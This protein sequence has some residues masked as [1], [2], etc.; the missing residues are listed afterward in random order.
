MPATT[1][2]DLPVTGMTC[3]GC[4]R[5]I[6]TRL[7]KEEGVV[8]S[9]VS[10]PAGSVS[11]TYDSRRVGRD[12]IV[13][14]IRDIGFDVPEAAAG[15]SLAAATEASQRSHA[16]QQLR[17]VFVAA[18]LTIP[19][20]VLS[21]GRDFGIW[22]Q[23]AYAPWVN[24]LLFALATPVQFYCGWQF[25]VGTYRSIRRRLANMDMLVAMSTTTAYLYSAAV[26]VAL[27]FG[28]SILGHHVYFETSATIITLILLGRQIESRAQAR[29][30]SAIEKLLR[31]QPTTAR[32]RRNGNEVELETDQ[33]RRG[34]VVIVRPGERIPFDGNVLSGHS[35]VD[36]SM[37]TGE[38]LPVEKQP[39]MEV[40]G[41]TI[42]RQGLLTVEV[43]HVADESALAQI[44][45]Q[46]QRAQAT[47]APIQDLA[48]RISSLFV[49]VVIAVALL[50]LAVWW[51][52]LGQPLQGMLRMI[53]VL[54]ISCPCAMGL[55][56]PLA[57]TVGMG[58][59]G[60]NGILF[61][62]STALQ[63]L[64]DVTHV[65]LD[66]TGTITHGKLAVTDVVVA[67]DQSRETVLRLAAAAEQGSEHPVAAAIVAA[68]QQDRLQLPFP[69]EFAADPGQGV[70][71]VVDG[72]TIRVGRRGWIAGDQTTLP[73]HLEL[74]ATELA[75]QAKSIN[76]V[77]RG[78]RV[79]GL[80]AF[81]DTIKPSSPSA[82]AALRNAG[83][84]VSMITGDNRTTADAVAAK[85]GI[86]RVLAE[87]LPS[88]KFDR[89]DALKQS[90]EVVAMVG[91]GINDAPALAAAD[92]GVAIGTG[93]DVAIESAGV[94]L[95][96]GEL[97]L[98]SR[99]WRLSKATMRNIRQNLFWAFAYNVLLIPVAA[100]A[101]A[102]FSQLPLM[103]RELHP[104]MAALA[105]V[106][107]DL[108]IVAN[109][110][111]L[112]SIEIG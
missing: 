54:I 11:I 34:D 2:V 74:A 95:I 55:A 45:R 18:A 100:G 42:N 83:L 76:C 104:M 20:F 109:A 91:D 66:K 98:V 21:M 99:A 56:T 61:K 25:Y 59:G 58:R 88:E 1:T 107:S 43:E 70:T 63:R 51:L 29:T 101:L 108:V 71:A 5:S 15:E 6:E 80:I 30:G 40:V 87:T 112:R 7:A 26:M 33:V 72:S 81:A 106:L 19:L 84:T 49:P 27:S 50:S 31:M 94:T 65:V 102:G 103:L 12:R 97:D 82:I 23:W 85:V 38:S 10:L 69:E 67:A 86:D 78:D 75:Q 24:Y 73:S 13:Q 9:V 46:V 28:A 110:L 68:A 111:R 35:A 96:G 92:V 16:R 32:V 64:G 60:E 22:G 36:E 57:V 53:A 90:G 105:M 37:I 77:A 39:G 44:V 62:S 93:T 14:S 41:A 52:V 17:L 48:D 4:A 47:K 8:E 89:V 3:A 79:I